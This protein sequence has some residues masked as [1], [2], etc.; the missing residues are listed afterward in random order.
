M[1]AEHVGDATL[2]AQI[3]RLV[4]EAQRSKAPIQDLADRVS[5]RFVPAVMVIAILTFA[6]WMIWGPAPKFSHA[7]VNAVATMIAM[8]WHPTHTAAMMRTATA[9]T[10][11]CENFGAIGPSN[12]PRGKV[13]MAIT[14]HRTTVGGNHKRPETRSARS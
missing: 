14:N 7:L 4:G 12:H 8:A 11:A 13:R 1:R 6:A 5:A 10:N 2:L 9:F 3:V